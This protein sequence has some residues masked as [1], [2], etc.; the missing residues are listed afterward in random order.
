MRSD[1][2]IS[3]SI[4]AIIIIVIVVVA[5]A[6]FLAAR[7]AKPSP[8][9]GATATTTTTTAATAT[10]PTAT[11]T[12]TT[13][14]TT[15]TTTTTTTTPT[16]TTTATTTATKHLEVLTIGSSKIR[17]P[18]DFYDFAMKAKRGEVHVTINFWTS[19]LPFEVE[20]I[21]SV[22]DEF[23]KEYPGIT[24]KYTGTVQNMKEAVK[25]GIIAGDVEH[26]ADVFTWA[27]DWTGELAEGGYIVPIDKYLPPE[28]LQD[29]QSQFLSV[30]YSAGVYKLHLYGLPWAAEAIALVCNADMVRSLPST[31]AEWKA[32]MEK[33]YNPDNETYG[34]AYQI[35][36]YFIYP[37]ITAFGGYYYDEANDSVGVNSTGTVEGMKFLIKNI[38]PYMYTGDLGHEIQL[39]VFLDGRA[40]CIITGPWDL[41]AIKEKIPNIIVGPIPEIDGRT[42]KPFSGIKLLWITKL[43]EQDKNRL[44][45]SILF[46]MWFSINDDTLKMLIDQAGF[47]PVKLSLVQYVKENINE[48]PIVAGFIKSVSNSVPMPKSPKMAKVWGPVTNALNAILSTYAEKGP[49]AALEI[50]EETMNAAQKEILESFAGG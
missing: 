7:H 22:V 8:P 40:P 18:A 29:L 37:F 33:Y 6:A 21:Q 16:T 41:P 50:V 38:L 30:A 34:L 25:A 48:Y 26:T 17:V 10:T 4:A 44:Y 24:V 15:T 42:P 46:A 45:A 35:D 1:R 12:K 32:I 43:A 14:A 31:Y 23:M 13:T 2:S 27:H 3:Y 36:P 5:A 47:I 49:Q 28:T 19:M 11:T 39:K 9:T 20:V